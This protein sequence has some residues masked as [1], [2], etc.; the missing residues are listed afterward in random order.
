MKKLSKIFLILTFITLLFNPLNVLAV[1][2]GETPPPPEENNMKVDEDNENPF[3]YNDQPENKDESNREKEIIKKPINT[4]A[5]VTGETYQGSG[6]VVDFTTTGAKAFYTVKG[7]DNT[8]YYIVIDM[9]KTENNVYFLSEINGE[10]L[11]LNEV[12]LKSQVPEEKMLE[13]QK[14]SIDETETK[15]K[16]SNIFFYFIL[17]VGSIGFLIYHMFFGKLKDNPLFDR[18][19]NRKDKNDNDL[20]NQENKNNK[21]PEEKELSE[22]DVHLE[23]NGKDEEEDNETHFV[24]DE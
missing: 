17:I 15:N 19:K 11:S 22:H 6:S 7:A 8:I 12:T 5:S 3:L 20:S 16:N 21:E 9:D 14:P 18:F 4:P 23:S 2:E 24:K 13:E 1:E 10:E